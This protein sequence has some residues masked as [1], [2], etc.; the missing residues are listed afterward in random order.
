MPKMAGGFREDCLPLGA[1]G[2]YP[3]SEPMLSIDLE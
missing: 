2:K 1:R 3:R